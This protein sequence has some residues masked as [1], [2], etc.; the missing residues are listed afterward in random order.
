MTANTVSSLIKNSNYAE[1][2]RDLYIEF[3]N[4]V[5][6]YADIIVK[7]PD[8]SQGSINRLHMSKI[9][10]LETKRKRAMGVHKGEKNY[11]RFTPQA[12]AILKGKS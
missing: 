8:F 1:F 3:G 11:W 2:L 4:G 12:K 10:E 9:I 6:S 5:F 7:F